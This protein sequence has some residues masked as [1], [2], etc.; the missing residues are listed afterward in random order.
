MLSDSCHEF[1]SSIG[2]AAKRLQ[3]DVE[4][5]AQPPFDYDEILALREACSAVVS[6]VSARPWTPED[7]LTLVALA[8]LT[9]RFHDTPRAT[10]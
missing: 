8:Y 9:L 6:S 4:H 10:N 5:Y 3:S 7:M 1:L 2:K